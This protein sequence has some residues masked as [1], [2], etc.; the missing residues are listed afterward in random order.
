MKKHCRIWS[1]ML[2]LVLLCTL[3]PVQASANGPAPAPWY[4]FYVTNIPEETVYVELLIR[5]SEKDSCYRSLNSN[6][7]PEGIAEGSPIVTYCE[8]GFRSYTFHYRDAR[9]QIRLT[10]EG[11]VT[12]FADGA[13]IYTSDSVA[14]GHLEDIE[15]RGKVRLAMLDAQGNILQVSRSLSIRPSGLFFYSMGIFYYDGAQDSLTVESYSSA[16][17]IILFLIVSAGGLLLTCAIEWLVALCFADI[18]KYAQLVFQTNFV[19]QLIM[20][21]A[22]IVLL[23]VLGS[24]GAS[25]P[26]YG[27]M[28]L[29]EIPVYF[30]EFL[31]YSTRMQEVSRRRCLCYT[32]CANTAS[33]MVGLLFLRAVM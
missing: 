23:W 24:L 20:R 30:C 22:Q 11:T 33:M 26:Y 18:K 10:E 4:T 21:C 9:A 32:L 31:F 2:V 15:G 1:L 13:Q 7:L 14:V 16:W 6:N 29:L 5:L 8:D 28:L 17:M 19:S 25:L 3:L 12:F 27:I